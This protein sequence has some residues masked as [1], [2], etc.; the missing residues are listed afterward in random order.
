M[1]TSDSVARVTQRR[2]SAIPSP[3]EGAH[4][5]GLQRRTLLV[6]SLAQVLAGFG[7]AAGITVGAL[8]A[9][10]LWGSTAA[11]GLPA[12]LFTLGAAG[13]SIVIARVSSAR[14]RRVGLTVGY[15]AGALGG[16]GIVIAATESLPVLLIVAFVIY[17][18][19]SAANLQARFAG[20]DL[21]VPSHRARAMSLV[22]MATTLGA[23]LGPLSAQLMGRVAEGWGLDALVGPFVLSAFAYVAGALVLGFYLRPDPLLVARTNDAPAAASGG[24]PGAQPA[25]TDAHDTA[26]RRPV[27]G[28]IVVMVGAQLVMIA[29]MTMT[30][31]QMRLHD[32][33]VGTIGLVIALHVAA[34][35][36]PSPLSGYLVDRLGPWWVAGASAAVLGLAGLVSALA[37]P[38]ATATMTVGLVL[39]G[40]GWSLGMIS[41]SAIVTAAA[42]LRVRAR[43]QGRSDALISVAGA[44]GAGASGVIMAMAGFSALALGC[45][46]AALALGALAVAY[47]RERKAGTMAAS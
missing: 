12:V 3:V 6:L 1:R 46:A 18:A 33:A 42:P 19:G 23:V 5:A 38:T 43:V 37:D 15:V 17:G 24:G 32:H 39:L 22:L 20:A 14:G 9:A 35:Y 10:E 44:G 25:G 11:A 31:V 36:V 28:G 47:G 13:A 41:G 8:L 29:V 45:A 2:E 26:W 4:L 40:L 34:M 21:A 7:L 16:L 30:P 27:A